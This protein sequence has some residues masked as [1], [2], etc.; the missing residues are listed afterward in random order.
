MESVNAWFAVAYLLM[1]LGLVG[2]L[3]PLIPGSLLIWIG[4]FVWARADGFQHFGWPWLILLAGIMVLT[5][6]SD[7]LLTSTFTRRAGG[8]WMTVA[9]AIVGGLLGGV[10]LTI[11][12]GVGTIVGTILGAIL[13]IL[14]IEYRAQHDWSRAFKTALAYVV[15]YIASAVVQV[16]L[17]LIMIAIFVIQTRG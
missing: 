17:C 15:G 12:P 1:F 11:L 6:L 3:L 5:W 8:S 4:A 9:G 13:G 10:I 7:L 2:A 14:Y 16:A